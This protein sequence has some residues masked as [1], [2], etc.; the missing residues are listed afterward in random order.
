MTGKIRKTAVV[1]ASSVEVDSHN[2]FDFNRLNNLG[3]SSALLL[4]ILHY[5][6]PQINIFK[7]G[8]DVR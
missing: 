1:A 7:I 6:Q 3:R 4:L 2:I 5:L 8:T